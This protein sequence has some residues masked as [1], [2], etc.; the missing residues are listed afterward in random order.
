[1]NYKGNTTVK[2]TKPQRSVFDLGKRRRDTVAMAKLIPIH[3][4]EVLPGDVVNGGQEVLVRLAPTLAPFY[5]VITLFVHTFFVPIRLLYEDWEEFITGGRLGVGIDPVTAPIPPYFDMEEPV[6]S[7]LLGAYSLMDYMGV[8]TID[9]ADSALWAGK[10]LDLMPAAA[11]QLIWYEYY[12]DRNFVSDDILSFPL[13]SGEM[14]WG[15]ELENMLALR[16]RDFLKD[17]FTAA[18]PN[19]QRG[20]EVLMPLAGTGSVTYLPTSRVFETDGSLPIVG[21]AV[22]G[23]SDAGTPGDLRIN[24]AAIGQDGDTGRIENIDEVS[25]ETSSVSI[26][27]FRSAYALQ[28]WLERNEI[29]GS[30]YTESLQAHWAVR[31]QDSRL[32]RPEYLG[33]QRATVNISEVVSTAAATFLTAEVPQG[34]MAGHGIAY[35]NQG[36]FKYYCPEYGYIISILSIMPVPTYQQGLPRMFRRRTFLDWPWPTF[37]K[38]GEQPV[39]DWELFFDPANMVQDSSGNY[40]IF[41]YQSRYADWKQRQNSNHGDFRNSLLFWSL[42]TPY[43]STP[44]LDSAFLSAARTDDGQIFAAD[45]DN[46]QFYWLLTKIHFMVKRQLPY[47]GTPNTLNF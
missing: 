22:I 39:W 4:E 16:E 6:A 25:L 11:Y 12:R 30:R 32:Q 45:I 47:Y 9:N 15:T 40:P 23:T 8:P 33:G 19:T 20:V 42:T 41:G 35:A 18:Q 27:D 21:D 2:L 44:T 38:L 1:M 3:C 5:D 29:A 24:I 31:P 34:N 7:S 37:A 10:E 28:V 14:A 13:A 43:S 46:G 36:Q 17:Y 26:N